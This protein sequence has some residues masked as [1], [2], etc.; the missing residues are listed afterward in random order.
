MMMNGDGDDL[1]HLLKA[2]MVYV[3]LIMLIC[4]TNVVGLSSSA[5]LLEQVNWLPFVLNHI[6]KFRNRVQRMRYMGINRA[7][8]RFEA[9]AETKDLFY[10][11]VRQS[12]LLSMS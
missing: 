7:K 1:W 5:F 8:S 11:L 12:R 3:I 9:G 4:A 2:G 6:P 10:F